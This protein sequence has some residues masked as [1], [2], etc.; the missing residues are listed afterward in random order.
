MSEKPWIFG[1]YLRVEGAAAAIDWYVQALGAKEKERVQ[2]ADGKI[3]HA[4][5]EIHGHLLCLADTERRGQFARPNNY[6]DVP[7]TL[8]AVVPDADAIFQR[9]I[10]CG[11]RSDRDST[12]QPYGFRAAG[13]IDPFGHVWYVLSALKESAA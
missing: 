2:I 6:N 8:Y 13:F 7:I 3:M 1:P 10:E 11:A 5:L 9:A 12:D 4:E